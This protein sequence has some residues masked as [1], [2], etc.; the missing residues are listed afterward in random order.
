MYTNLNLISPFSYQ[1]PFQVI[2]NRI[3]ILTLLTFILLPFFP[4]FHFSI[5]IS[6]SII[7]LCILNLFIASSS[8]QQ[9][10]LFLLLIWFFPHLE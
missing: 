6:L 4:C 9:G 8:V 10:D 5:A 2:A 7:N 1:L 3:L